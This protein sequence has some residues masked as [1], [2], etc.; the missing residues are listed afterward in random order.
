MR[1]RTTAHFERNGYV[2]ILEAGRADRAGRIAFIRFR[3]N[4]GS[5][6]AGNLSV[7]PIAIRRQPCRWRLRYGRLPHATGAG[8]GQSGFSGRVEGGEW[9]VA[10]AENRDLFVKAPEKYAPQFGGYCA[11]AVAY[12]ST[13]AGDPRV[14]TLANG[15]L[16]LNLN[17]SVQST[18]ARDRDNLIKRAETNWPTVLK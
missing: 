11:F 5:A 15:K 7:G 9:P 14:F 1:V 17:Q 2:A 18:W 6:E 12:G 4:R 8:A 3:R 16:Y 13:A 10:S